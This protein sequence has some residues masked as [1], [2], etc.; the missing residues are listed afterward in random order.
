[1]KASAR[2]SATTTSVAAARRFIAQVLA[3]IDRPALETIALMVS[4]LATNCVRHAQTSYTITVRRGDRDIHVSVRDGGAGH[5]RVRHPSPSDTH[6]RGLQIV[7]ALAAE[8]G[9]DEDPKRP[10]KTAWFSY[11]L[12]GSAADVND[13]LARERHHGG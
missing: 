13:S 4:E 8:W 7:S 12:G 5:A 9:V 3:G 11:P 6:G 10:G 1:M 2:F